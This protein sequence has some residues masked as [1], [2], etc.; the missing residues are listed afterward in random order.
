MSWGWRSVKSSNLPP[1]KSRFQINSACVCV[2]ACMRV[3]VCRCV[4]VCVC[5][6]LCVCVCVCVCVWHGKICRLVKEARTQF[7]III[8]A[9]KLMKVVYFCYLNTDKGINDCIRNNTMHGSHDVAHLKCG[10]FSP[11]VANCRAQA[12]GFTRVYTLLPSTG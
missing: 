2:S 7:I 1:T 5:V 4:C 12:T 3:G 6:C 10:S 11:T 9:V 8:T